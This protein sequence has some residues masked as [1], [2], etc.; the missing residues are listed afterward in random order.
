MNKHDN[1]IAFPANARRPAN[2]PRLLRA[3]SAGAGQAPATVLDLAAKRSVRAKANATATR[4]RP[5][6]MN[7]VWDALNQDRIE[8]HYQP[9]YDLA[10]G[11]IMGAE[12]LLRLVDGQGQLV[13]PDRFSELV[14]T[15][16]LIVPLGRAVIERVCAD[17]VQ[18]RAEG[19]VLPRVAINLA[20]H[21]LNSDDGLVGFIDDTLAEHSLAYTDLEFE[22]TERQR[23][24]TNG[25]GSPA[26]IALAS[27]GAKI[28]IDDF[29]IGYSSV[30][31]LTELPISTFK[32][33]RALIGRLPEDETM[34]SVV[35]A[36][37]KLAEHLGLD[38]VA[39]GVET[40]AQHQWLKDAG[41]PSGQGFGYAKP[42]PIA[43]LQVLLNEN[44]QPDITINAASLR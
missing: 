42:M 43:K 10:T 30:V 41:C 40:Q 27:R 23:L 16:D 2:A 13:Y 19:G 38:V 17:L 12:A 28:T 33:D 15:S 8:M 6:T 11:E 37:L 3:G 1:I 32:L 29:G 14:E 35:T 18:I 4:Q 5:L 44:I 9:Q 31:C 26:L 34:Q 36:L 7:E 24:D 39:E 25:Q 21:Q 20:A 22:L